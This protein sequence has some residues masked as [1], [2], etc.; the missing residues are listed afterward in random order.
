MDEHGPMTAGEAGCLL[1]LTSVISVA[2]ALAAFI[3]VGSN[4]ASFV[5]AI[6]AAI[7]IPIAWWLAR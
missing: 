5:A 1:I 6:L 4:V 7:G 3:F 2:A